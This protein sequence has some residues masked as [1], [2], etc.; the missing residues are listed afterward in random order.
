MQYEKPRL[1]RADEI[2]CRAQVVKEYGF[3]L[4]LYKDS[5]VDMQVLDETYGQF[6]WQRS[7]SRDNANC[8]ISIWDSDKAQWVSKEDVGTE[9]YTEKEKGLASDSFKRAGFNWNIGRELYTAPFIWI[10]AKDGEVYKDGDKWKVNSK[11]YFYVDHIA[12][13]DNRQISELIIRDKDD[14][15]RFTHGDVTETEDNG[16]S[17][18]NG[19]SNSSQTKKP[20]PETSSQDDNKGNGQTKSSSSSNGKADPDEFIENCDNM[21]ELIGWWKENKDEYGD[22]HKDKVAKRLDEIQ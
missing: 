11:A 4:L 13:N 18:T 21:E 12:Y 3:S 5:R 8:V 7:H 2:Q 15:V 17:K 16:Q 6:N 19:T 14:N 9:S 22:T 10:S 1:L 20:K